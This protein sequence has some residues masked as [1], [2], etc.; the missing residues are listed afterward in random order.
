MSTRSLW[1]WANAYKM[2]AAIFALEE[3]GALAAMAAAPR[4]IEELSW[5]D[6]DALAPLL[7][8]LLHA[9]LLSCEDGRYSLVGGSLLP[10]LA[11]E[12]RVRSRFSQEVIVARLRGQ[13]GSDP[14]DAPGAEARWPEYHAAMSVS[15]R[16]IAPHVVRVTRL[17]RGEHVID[18][19]GA[20]G[21]LFAALKHLVPGIRGTV[22]DRP[23][24][25]P[26]W[27]AVEDARFVGLDL[28]ALDGD[29]L[30]D[31]DVVLLSNVLHLFNAADR[32]VMMKKILDHVRPGARAVVYDVFVSRGV[33]DAGL[34]MVLDWMLCGHRF[35]LTAEQM[36]S[37][38]VSLGWSNPV[39]HIV[40]TLPGAFVSALKPASGATP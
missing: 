16:S 36:A 3:V 5:L 1:H 13:G 10:L 15:A 37:E 39:T 32:G 9:G 34:F 7:T 30:A 29:L 33:A 20:D 4:S 2:S 28:R 6:A 25:A 21:A 31:A 17:R 24:A 40:P 22:V 11:H 26:H 35:D 18:L 19:G 27:R 38:L 14:M 23:S 12:R 8:M